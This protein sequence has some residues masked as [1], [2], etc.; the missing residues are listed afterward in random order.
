MASVELVDACLTFPLRHLKGITLKEL[1]TRQIFVRNKKPAMREVRALVD[2]TLRLQDGDRLAII[3]HN[4]AGKST[5]LRAISG[6]YPIDRGGRRVEGQICS[7]FDITLGFEREATGWENIHY[8]GYLQGET[9]KSIRHKRDAIAE[10]SE[11]G[12]FLDLPV[13]CYSTGMLMRLAF[14]VATAIEPEILLIDE[15][16]STG[17]LAF[18]E[19]S[20]RRM[21]EMMAK[22]RIIVIVAHDLALLEQF[23][24]RAVWM[25]HAQIRQAGET[26]RIIAAYRE[27]A[28]Q[29][30]AA[31]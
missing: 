19:K 4:G 9:P 16:F 5:L 17:D 21:Q 23:C 1:L 12:D 31:A 6:V 15:V 13:R 27:S 24:N 7:L 29:T 11:L 10:F 28:Y 20:R 18:Q 2:I 30:R 26:S 22:A 3:G 25:D 8:R 14:S